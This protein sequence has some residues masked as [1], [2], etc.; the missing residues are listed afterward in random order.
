MGRNMKRPETRKAKAYRNVIS[1]SLD[2][3]I[4]KHSEKEKRKYPIRMNRQTIIFA[5]R[6]KLPKG[7]EQWC[8]FR[9]GV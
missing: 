7:Y 5:A 4:R 6:K 1:S 8:S 2:E 9:K 3:A